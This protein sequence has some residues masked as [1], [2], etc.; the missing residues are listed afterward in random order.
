MKELFLVLEASKV[1]GKLDWERVGKNLAATSS[2]Q[3]VLGIII[4]LLLYIAW[5]ITVG[6]GVL[7]YTIWL[8][9]YAYTVFLLPLGLPAITF[10]TTIGV[11]LIHKLL[12]FGHT[13]MLAKTL[14]NTNILT[15]KEKKPS[16]SQLVFGNLF[17][18]FVMHVIIW[19]FGHIG[20]FG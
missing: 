3:L 12:G 19:S 10:T 5:Q 11:Y 18:L 15:L 20:F 13:N 8:L 9:K 1:G 17:A 14:H 7:L 6:I 4:L 16:W 2:T